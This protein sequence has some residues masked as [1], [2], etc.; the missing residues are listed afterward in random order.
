MNSANTNQLK[1][2]VRL[3]H[4]VVRRR[5]RLQK[6][7]HKQHLAKF[8]P[9]I[10]AIIRRYG[11]LLRERRQVI[12]QVLIGIS[13][14]LRWIVIPLF[15]APDYLDGD[16]PGVAADEVDDA[17]AEPDGVQPEP[18][19]GAGEGDQGLDALDEH[20]TAGTDKPGR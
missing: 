10:R 4:A 13:P 17:R 3:L 14:V 1:C 19:C 2:L 9:E 20:P 18:T 12:L 5:I 16:E 8:M 6:E 15:C 7:A 11:E